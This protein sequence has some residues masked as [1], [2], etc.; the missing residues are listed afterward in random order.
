MKATGGKL[1]LL[2][3]YKGYQYFYDGDVTRICRLNP[4]DTWS[5]IS[6]QEY[7]AIKKQY[8]QEEF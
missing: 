7:E 2:I 4:D 8:D 3:I 5:N 1:V 6:M